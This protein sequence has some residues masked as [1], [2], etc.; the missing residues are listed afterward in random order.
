VAVGGGINVIFIWSFAVPVH[1]DNALIVIF[2]LQEPLL[3]SVALGKYCGFKIYLLLKVPVPVLDQ[4]MVEYPAAVAASSITLLPLQ[5][6]LSGPA[7]TL[8]S[9]KIVRIFSSLTTNEQSLRGNALN[10]RTTD[11]FSRS[12]MLG[13]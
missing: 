12:A 8:G 10:V 13:V 2:R 3:S 4:V 11:P 6:D 1:G 5:T 9:G 7:L